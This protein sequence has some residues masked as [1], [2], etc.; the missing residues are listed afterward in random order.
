MDGEPLRPLDENEMSD[1][2]STRALVGTGF[3]LHTVLPG[4]DRVRVSDDSHYCF[5]LPI[6]IDGE[7]Q[8]GI[9]WDQPPVQSFTAVESGP[10]DFIFNCMRRR[11]KR[12]KKLAYGYTSGSLSSNLN[13]NSGQIQNPNYDT[14]NPHEDRIGKH[15]QRL[16]RQ[17]DLLGANNLRNF[18]T[19]MQFEEYS[20]EFRRIFLT[21]L[22]G[23]LCGF[24]VKAF[25][26]IDRDEVFVKV[27]LPTERKPLDL[28]RERAESEEQVRRM[29]AADRAASKI[30]GESSERLGLSNADRL[31]IGMR[32]RKAIKEEAY[33]RAHEVRKTFLEQAHV[34]EDDQILDSLEPAYSKHKVFYP[35]YAEFNLRKYAARRMDGESA[36]A[37]EG[38]IFSPFEDF[39]SA[40]IVKMVRLRIGTL[41]SFSKMFQQQMV[42]SH[43]P[44]HLYKDLAEINT[45]PNWRMDA[46]CLFWPPSHDDAGPYMD[47][48]CDKIRNYFGE[49]VAFFCAFGIDYLRELLIP[50]FFGGLM[51]VLQLQTPLSGMQTLRKCEIIFSMFVT[52][53]AVMFYKKCIKHE[54]RKSVRW[55]M[56]GSNL[57]S[58]VLPSYREDLEGS[59]RVRLSQIAGAVVVLLFFVAIVVQIFTCESLRRKIIQ[60]PGDYLEVAE[61]VLEQEFVYETVYMAQG[62]NQTDPPSRRVVKRWISYTG[63]KVGAF[64]ITLQIKVFDFVWSIVARKICAYENHRT[65]QQ[66]QDSLIW[67]L[68]TVKLFNL[69]YPYMYIA[70]IKEFVEGCP[71]VTCIPELQQALTVFFVSDVVLRL[72]FALFQWRWIRSAVIEEMASAEEGCRIE[73]DYLELQAKLPAPDPVMVD[74]MLSI[75]MEFAFTCTFT[76]AMPVLPLVALLK[77]SVMLKLVMHRRSKLMQRGLPEPSEGI[78]VWKDMLNLSIN[79]ACVVSASIAV[80]AMQPMKDFDWPTKLSAFICIEHMLIGIKFFVDVVVDNEAADVL[81]AVEQNEAVHH[82]VLLP[83]TDAYVGEKCTPAG[84]PVQLREIAPDVDCGADGA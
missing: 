41:F 18:R 37:E 61:P 14:G 20:S 64:L 74:D 23:D 34:D 40:D 19:T 35:A 51:F 72:S 16:F 17:R 6:R 5:V 33:T 39:S 68:F 50:G 15:A 67:K 10:L 80:F 65:M 55:G 3:K 22:Q 11:K 25:V 4:T 13:P 53:W 66:L 49:E 70:F 76:I 48:H 32:M 73:Y 82:V 54:R 31:A 83:R 62:R 7:P 38:I 30:A 59:L 52:A 56:R 47:D 78:G 9:Y 60:H 58:D 75:V 21:V 8:P 29:S 28:T 44:V 42:V 63:G 2:G 36:E 84:Y 43:F 26:S 57:N 12:K 77:S 46:R 45:H 79:L 71:E 81:Q 24:E 27:R 1:D 69:M